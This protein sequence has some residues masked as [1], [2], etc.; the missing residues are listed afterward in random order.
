MKAEFKYS[1]FAISEI[2]KLK[3]QWKLSSCSEIFLN[4][5]T[6]VFLL[7]PNGCGPQAA[8]NELRIP[9]MCVTSKKLYIYM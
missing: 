3:C 7:L 9:S 5:H 2:A 4:A 6:C 1:E 8:E